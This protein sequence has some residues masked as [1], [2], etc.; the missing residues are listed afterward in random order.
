MQFPSGE[1]AFW[2]VI[3][4]LHFHSNTPGRT[5]ENNEINILI[6]VFRFSLSE[7]EEM[8]ENQYFDDDILFFVIRVLTSFR[9]LPNE[10]LF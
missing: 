2:S 6:T 8:P 4:L 10:R 1:S 5:F 7:C 3:G 9:R